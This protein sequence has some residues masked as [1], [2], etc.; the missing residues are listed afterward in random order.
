MGDDEAEEEAEL[1]LELFSSPHS[2]KK[3]SMSWYSLDL[4]SSEM[5]PLVLPWVETDVD[6]ITVACDDKEVGVDW[7]GCWICAVAGGWSVLVWDLWECL[8]S[9]LS[10]SLSGMI[11]LLRGN[12]S[13]VDTPRAVRRL[14]LFVPPKLERLKFERWWPLLLLLLFA[15]FGKRVEGWNCWA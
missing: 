10:T 1:E 6:E 13:L 2:S 4:V 15:V 11:G 5:T 14:A 9:A 8:L 12:T 3:S 7:V